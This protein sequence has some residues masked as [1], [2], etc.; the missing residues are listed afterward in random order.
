MARADHHADE[1]EGAN[2][3]L[4]S[5]AESCS[6]DQWRMIVPGENWSVGTLVH[7]CALGHAT[8]SSWIRE[9]I[10]T[11]AVSTTA[12]ELDA[13][14]ARHAA[15][16]AN[17]AITETVDLLRRNGTAA[18]GVL[19]SLSDEELEREAAFGPAGGRIFKVESFAGM[20]SR[21]PI[22]HLANARAAIATA[23][24]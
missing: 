9:M 13:S 4:I 14:N 6:E 10:E 7:H 15:D 19:R 3:E 18:A 12:E 2:A 17:P 8:A 21:H 22:S 11:G 16:F 5:F 24:A 20:F 1:L 23:G